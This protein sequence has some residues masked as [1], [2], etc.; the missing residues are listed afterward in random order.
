MAGRKPE[1]TL[2]DRLS[3]TMHGRW[4]ADRVENMVG[5]DM[6][7][8]FFVLPEGSGWIELKQIF[9]WN[10]YPHRITKVPHFTRGQ[11]R[12]LSS[13]HREG[14]NCWLLLHVRLTDEYIFL[15]GD[16]AGC[17]GDVTQE[18]VYINSYEHFHGMPSNAAIQMIL[19][20][21]GEE[22]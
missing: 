3:A 8:V 7:D 5:R 6:P 18:E 21:K 9:R 2:W 16:K 12:W 20:S 14:A 10:H 1:Q 15:T 22:E 4:M 13:R 17:V 11:K 19:G